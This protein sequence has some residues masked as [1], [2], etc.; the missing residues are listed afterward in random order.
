VVGSGTNPIPHFNTQR[1]CG[2]VVRAALQTTSGK[3]ILGVGSM[4]SWTEYLKIWCEVN[5]VPFG[6]FD[7]IPLDVFEK[8]VPVPG[9]GKEMGEMLAFMDEF[10]YDGRDPTVI[11]ASNVSNM[12]YFNLESANCSSQIG[13]PCPLTTW[14][15]Y[16]NEQ[17]WSGILNK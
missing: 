8:V 13:V 9:L 5:K 14:E 16:V 15:A 10:G 6:G 11:H 7:S 2:Y 12:V 1:D 3:N 17:D 4:L